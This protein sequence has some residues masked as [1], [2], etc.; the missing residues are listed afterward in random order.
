MMRTLLWAVLL[1]G[2][3]VVSSGCGLVSH[4]INRTANLLTNP[5]RSVAVPVE[6]E[7][8]SAFRA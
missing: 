5:L 2:T 6:G 1:L 4:Q 3:S 8:A 7:E